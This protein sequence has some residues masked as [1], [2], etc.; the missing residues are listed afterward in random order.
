M[1]KVK[2]KKTTNSA[3]L[4]AKGN[5]GD[6]CHDVW[7]VSEEEI[8]PNVWKYRLGFKYE[9]ERPKVFRPFSEFDPFNM[10]P[11]SLF[12]DY[13]ICIKF[14]PRSSIYKT[15]MSLANSEG[16]LDEFYRGEACAIFY[17]VLPNMER[18]HAG[19]R[20]GQIYVDVAPKVEFEEV[21]EINEDTER[22][23]GGFGSTGK[24]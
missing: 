19:D 7:A 6:F 11:R 12:D 22:G 17:H 20:I 23:A 9:I 24:N 10:L 13:E 14:K 16:T 8:A 15:G 21:E 18:Y 2:I 4:P 3:K 1:I 5:T